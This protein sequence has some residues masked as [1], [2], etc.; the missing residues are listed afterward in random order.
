[1]MDCSARHALVLSF[2]VLAPALLAQPAPRRPRGICAKV[3]IASEITAQQKANPAV[4][5]AQLNT[6]FN[7][8][9][10][11]LL[12]NPAIS[13]LVL[14]VHWDTVNPA[15]NSYDWTYVDDAFEQAALWNTRNPGR[16]AKTSQFTVTPGF[17]TPQWV[18]DQIPS[19]DGL[20]QTPCRSCTTC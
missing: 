10:Q 4:T 6:R 19:C 17:Q 16:T 7:N 15:P 1:M 8:L 18:L 3:N 20:F 9:Y 13:G 11:D 12:N 5:P 14:Q 2:L